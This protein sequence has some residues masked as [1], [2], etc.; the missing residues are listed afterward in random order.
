MDAG[1]VIY[2]YIWILAIKKK[3]FVIFNN[4]DESW[5]HYDKWNKSDKE[6]EMLYDLTHMWNLKPT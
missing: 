3:K 5:E 4:I 6:R 1:N 2:I